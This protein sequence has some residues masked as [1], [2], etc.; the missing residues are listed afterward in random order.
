MLSLRFKGSLPI[1]ALLAARGG[2]RAEGRV[3]ALSCAGYLHSPA[4]GSQ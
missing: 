4:A 1:R 3:E 2:R